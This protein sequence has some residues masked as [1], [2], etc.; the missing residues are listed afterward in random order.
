[1]RTLLQRNQS[2]ENTPAYSPVRSPLIS[3]WS[4]F[5]NTCVKCMARMLNKG[6]NSSKARIKILQMFITVSITMKKKSL[7]K[8]W[9]CWLTGPSHL[10]LHENYIN[11]WGYFLLYLYVINLSWLFHHHYFFQ[12]AITEQLVKHHYVAPP[13][14]LDEMKN[15]RSQYRFFMNNMMKAAM[16]KI[17]QV[18]T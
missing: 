17:S 14:V 3:S 12:I 7:L 5:W 10:D 13:T 2:T 1:M 4:P 18:F 6:R 8:R 9:G 11:G 15:I 16:L